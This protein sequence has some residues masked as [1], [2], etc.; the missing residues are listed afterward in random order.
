MQKIS[1]SLETARMDERIGTI[2]NDMIPEICSLIQTC[3]IDDNYYKLLLSFFHKHSI[4]DFPES[5]HIIQYLIGLLNSPDI[6]LI[7]HGIRCIFCVLCQKTFQFNLEFTQLLCSNL[8]HLL[9]CDSSIILIY[10]LKILSKIAILS[11]D[12]FAIVA[13]LLPPEQLCQ[14]IVSSNNS[15]VICSSL[16]L[17]M[18]YIKMIFNHRKNMK[19]HYQTEE[20][21][22]IHQKRQ[23]ELCKT[24]CFISSTLIAHFHTDIEVLNYTVKMC[25]LFAQ[26]HQC[27]ATFFEHFK[28]FETIYSLLDIE[29]IALKQNVII[30]IRLYLKTQKT[31]RNIDIQKV[32]P[33]INHD[34]SDLQLSAINCI[35]EFVFRNPECVYILVNCSIFDQ[36]SICMNNGSFKARMSCIQ[37]LYT[38]LT[39]KEELFIEISQIYF[40]M[41]LFAL[42]TELIPETPLNYLEYIFSLL[43]KLIK[44]VETIN[45]VELSQTL[46][47][48]FE[49]VNGE[50]VF[51]NFVQDNEKP[52]KLDNGI[53][54]VS[55]LVESFDHV[56]YSIRNIEEKLKNTDTCM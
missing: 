56:I 24:I 22:E 10:L 37:L 46:I 13:Q 36:I 31:I 14:S 5:D 27:W 35:N 49:S 2:S 41:N 39:C 7:T 17:L 15:K 43:K 4:N 32:I 30:L 48:Q 51:E 34:V 53:S 26:K 33:Y 6:N 55:L 1:D 25:V 28:L 47:Q 40:N 52:N 20:E 45:Q 11:F 8:S 50:D 9:N 23:Q 21:C 38:I 44:Y 29:S 54:P 16:L 19:N 3:P 18:M 12:H 42:L